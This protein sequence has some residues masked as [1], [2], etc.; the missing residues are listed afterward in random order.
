MSVPI[1]SRLFYPGL[2]QRYVILSIGKLVWKSALIGVSL[3]P[4]AVTVWVLVKTKLSCVTKQICDR[5]PE[6]NSSHL[7]KSSRR[8]TRGCGRRITYAKIPDGT[9]IE[10]EAISM[11][12]GK[13]RGVKFLADVRKRLEQIIDRDGVDVEVDDKTNFSTEG[14]SDC[15]AKKVK[16]AE[17]E[18]MNSAA[19]FARAFPELRRRTRVHLH[20]YQISNSLKFRLV[21]KAM[22]NA[23]SSKYLEQETA[24]RLDGYL[25]LWKQ[26]YEAEGVVLSA[27]TLRAWELGFR[28]RIFLGMDLD[29]PKD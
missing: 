22:Q 24:I 17:I 7:V 6:V 13:T 28:L 26:H 21:S 9:S 10:F 12:V 5:V 23:I 19:T 14:L 16:L 20:P 27:G 3:V 25:L 11:L 29:F 4:V 1:Y 15:D 8:A 18:E 2:G